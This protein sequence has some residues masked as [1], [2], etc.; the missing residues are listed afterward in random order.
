[1]RGYQQILKLFD[2][3]DERQEA[4]PFGDLVE[5]LKSL[6]LERAD[7][8]SALVFADRSYRRIAIRR[9]PHYEAL[10]LCWKSGQCS[11]IHN[12]LRSSCVIRVVEG[13]A[14]E[15][16]YGFSPCG[17]LVPQHSRTYAAG[18]VTG[19]RDEA[20]HQMANLGPAG[21]DLIT[22]HV[23][24][25]PPRCWNYLELERTTLANHDALLR[26]GS[27]TLVVDFG[28]VTGHTRERSPIDVSPVP[29][30]PVAGPV[31]A[32]VGGGLS[33]TLVAV[34]M[35]RL[36]ANKPPRTRFFEKS[37]TSR[38]SCLRHAVRSAPAQCI[39]WFDDR[40]P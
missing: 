4:V 7:L 20:I 23:Y 31:I 13:L 39:G 3:W 15:T 10:V 37:N 11:P 1:M 33:G 38:R 14:T 22:L 18:R 17:K 9:R 12:H 32:I 16:R 36:E 2:A 28:Q 5:S 35:T 40:L 19:C 34:H 26:E 25:P 30:S 8:A 6:E 27:Q 21:Q 29:A 24:S